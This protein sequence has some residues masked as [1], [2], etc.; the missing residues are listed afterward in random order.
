M[1]YDFQ[2]LLTGISLYLKLNW[3]LNHKKIPKLIKITEKII[4]LF[5]GATGGNIYIMKKKK[6]FKFN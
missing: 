1:N 5:V 3:F 4:G 6:I 2:H